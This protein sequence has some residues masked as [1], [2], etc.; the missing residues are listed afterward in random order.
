LEITDSGVE[1]GGNDVLDLTDEGKF[2]LSNFLVSFPGGSPVSTDTF[3]GG[4]SGEGG[5]EFFNRFFEDV[6]LEGEGSFSLS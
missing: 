4:F 1:F 3:L 2:V 6:F 5:S